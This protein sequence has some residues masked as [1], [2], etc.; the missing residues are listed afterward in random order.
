MFHR[1][2][3]P[4][5]FQHIGV[6]ESVGGLYWVHDVNCRPVTWLSD[7][8]ATLDNGMTAS[9]VEYVCKLEFAWLNILSFIWTA[10][11]TL[12]FVIE[13]LHLW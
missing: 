4:L 12:Y 2:D 3:S 9:Q 5:G 11:D 1:L 7:L 13:L 10:T 6:I 8:L